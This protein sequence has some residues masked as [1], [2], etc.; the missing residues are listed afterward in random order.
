MTPS[1][2]VILKGYPRLSETFIAQELLAL[3]QRGLHLH[4]F[5]LRHPTD[6]SIHPVHREITAEVTYLPEYLHDEP[7]RVWRAWRK[8]AK[9]PGYRKARSIFLR[10]LLRDRTPNRIRRFG[11][12]CVLA[13][14]LPAGIKQLYAHFLHTPASVTR[15]AAVMTGLPWSASAHAKDIWTTPEWEK[16]EKLADLEWLV[17]CTEVGRDHL[18]ELAPD[19]DKVGLVYHGLDLTRFGP[20]AAHAPDPSTP[21]SAGNDNDDSNAKQGDGSD[22]E[23][24][25]ILLS[26]GR[27]VEKKGYNDLLTA[28][29]QLPKEL[30][31]RLVHIGGGKLTDKL[32][33]LGRKLG[34]DTRIDW[35]GAQPQ[36]VV[37]ENYRKA[38]LF[39]LASRIGSDG[40]RDGLPNVLMEAQ[41]Q[42]VACVSTAVSAIPELIRDGE[43]GLLVPPESPDD[44]A[45]ALRNLI[46]DPARRHRLATAGCQRVRSE[47]AMQS[48]VDALLSRFEQK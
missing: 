32:R 5:S 34:I 16:R 30:Q 43:T 48:G 3:E 27:A 19:P 45:A 46:V 24:P 35:L 4:F 47:F 6:T 31:W 41:S 9:L 17:T 37:L 20:N 22:P 28:L 42:A 40:D 44:L 18:A 38:D 33:A 26:V 25:V 14:E 2:A 36:E 1:I 21:D 11:Q 12:A 15:Y 7:A 23:N 10:D 39:V 29:A 8:A 13:A